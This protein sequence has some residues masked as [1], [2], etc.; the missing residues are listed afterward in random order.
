MTTAVP[1]LIC[2]F[3]PSLSCTAVIQSLYCTA[4]RVVPTVSS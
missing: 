1:G 2:N 3:S 4:L